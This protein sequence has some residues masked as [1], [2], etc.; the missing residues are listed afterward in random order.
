MAKTI[1][2]L[3]KTEVIRRHGPWNNP[4]AVAQASLAL[5]DGF[6]LRRRLDPVGTIP[7]VEAA[8]SDLRTVP[9]A[10]LPKAR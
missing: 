6:T 2:G 8:A 5:L 10:G 4:K 3:Y 7:P 9:R 1:K